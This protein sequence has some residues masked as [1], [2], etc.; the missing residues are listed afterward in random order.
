MT[1]ENAELLADYLAKNA[2]S[3]ATKV[4]NDITLADLFYEDY[5]FNLKRFRV[6]WW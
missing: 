6:I 4:I 5:L 2:I 1:P 3:P